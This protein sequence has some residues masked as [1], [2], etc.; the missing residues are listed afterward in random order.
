[1]NP[2]DENIRNLRVSGAAHF[3]FS[4]HADHFASRSTVISEFNKSASCHEIP[5]SAG[6][7]DHQVNAPSQ[8]AAS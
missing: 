3:L 2:I 7:H 4:A 6:N 8:E 5:R 1:M